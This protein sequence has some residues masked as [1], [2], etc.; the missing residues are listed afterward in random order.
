MVFKIRPATPDDA[1]ALAGCF[2]AAYAQARAT[3]PDLP[4]VSG[5]LAQDIAAHHVWIATG[6]GTE[7]CLGGLVL[8]L[9]PPRAHLI[10]VATVPAA[11]GM[12]IARAL[13]LNPSYGLSIERLAIIEGKAR[14]L[15]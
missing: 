8:G 9:D 5:G 4:D 3:I 2:R 13:L 15:R 7:P 12:G 1:Q 11:R 14:A 6:G 10:N